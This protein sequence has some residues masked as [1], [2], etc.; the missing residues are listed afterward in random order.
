[1][2]A[3]RAAAIERLL[4]MEV[5]EH[6]EAEAVDLLRAGLRVH[7][8]RA[9]RRIT[10]QKMDAA[11]VFFLL[12][13]EV[14]VTR[15]GKLVT[16][17]QAPEI[18]GLVA[19]IDGQPR[20]ASLEA[21]TN[22]R[23]AS[24]P[25][26][27]LEALL[28]ESPRMSR[29]L[30]RFLAHQLRL[31]YEQSDRIQRHFEDFFR[32]PKAELVPGPY[33]ADPFDMYIFV[34]QDD[35]RHLA[36]LLPRGV[37]P[38][39]GTEGRYLLTFNF[40]DRTWSRHPEGEG[41]AFSYNETAAF[42]P[43]IAP[44]MRPGLFIPELYPDNFLA[45]TLGRELYGFPK[46]FA[47]TTLAPERGIID[48]VLERRMT[49]RASWRDVEEVEAQTFLLRLIR[50]FWPR[51]V[52]EYARRIASSA[53]GLADRHV[54]EDRRPAMPVFVHKQI[55]DSAEGMT[56]GKA[57]DE[58][59]EIPFQVSDLGHFCRLDH[60]RVRFLDSEYFLGG[61]CLGGFRVNMGLQFGRGHRWLDYN[62]DAGTGLFGRRRR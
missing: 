11:Y 7:D 9:G 33:V 46:R 57:I 16:L 45:I 36:A 3:D 31:Q 20:T 21:F 2:T 52:P 5:F 30:I 22:V 10:D 25:H 4:Q 32:S 37:R 14:A 47:R 29:N 43:C 1:M 50:L 38:M 23:V 55:P 18:L 12:E 49:L 19:V 34:M 24:M 59:V 51:W 26:E 35:P 39:P 42:L 54:P 41:R 8:V 6:L 28:D 62:E 44:R 17:I 13:G 60:A 56:E 53:F 48:F 40:F 58:L 15:N 27:L 61:R